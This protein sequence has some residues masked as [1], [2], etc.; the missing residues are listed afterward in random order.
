MKLNELTNVLVTGLRGHGIEATPTTNTKNNGVVQHGLTLR[1]NDERVA[2][3]FYIN[4]FFERYKNGELSVDDILSQIIVEYEKLPTPSFPD[5]N[6]MMSAPDFI[7]KITLRLVNEPAN[8]STIE[9]RNLVHHQIAETDLVVLFYA[10]VVSDENSSGSIAITEELMK[11]YLPNVVDGDDLYE[12]IIHRKSEVV[13]F[14]SI[15]TVLERMMRERLE[16]IPQ[17][18]FEDDF[19]FVLTNGSTS[20]GAG[21]LFTDAAR[22]EILKKFPEGE[23]TVLPSSVHETLIL[24]TCEDENI[25]MLQEMVYSVNR[26]EV[27]REE[28]LSDD[29]FHYNAKTG[30]LFRMF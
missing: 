19:M 25:E 6:E 22:E 10:T 9:C 24:K 20:Y 18:P 16:E 27:S 29:V 15:G 30:K 2:P 12:K 7:D 17:I 4:Q 8:R 1:R 5:I 13:K 11:R 23:V 3:V 14:E 21:A 26:A 28:F